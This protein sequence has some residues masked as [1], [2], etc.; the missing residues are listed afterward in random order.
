MTSV[1]SYLIN[2]KETGTQKTYDAFPDDINPQAICQ[3]EQ[4]ASALCYRTIDQKTIFIFA[5]E[6]NQ[7]HSRGAKKAPDFN[8][9]MNSRKPRP[10]LINKCTFITSVRFF[11]D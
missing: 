11:I 10:Q 3:I 9:G 2:E 8:R 6:K 4:T 5:N 7:L 1:K